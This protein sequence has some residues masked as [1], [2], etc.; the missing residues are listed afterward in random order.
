M[1]DG[2]IYLYEMNPTEVRSRACRFIIAHCVLTGVKV[3]RES[4]RCFLCRSRC[5]H[6]M[7]WRAAAFWTLLVQYW[8]RPVRRQWRGRPWSNASFPSHAA[9]ATRIVRGH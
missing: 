3:P 7:V 1:L 5:I 6:R 2:W 4:S 8:A 9:A